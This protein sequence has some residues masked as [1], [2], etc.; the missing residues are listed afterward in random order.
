MRK[1]EIQHRSYE[2]AIKVIKLVSTL[3]KTQKGIEK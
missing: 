2:F 3:P 1:N